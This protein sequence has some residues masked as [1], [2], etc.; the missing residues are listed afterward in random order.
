MILIDGCELMAAGDEFEMLYGD[1]DR[2]LRP[3]LGPYVHTKSGKKIRCK[4][5]KVFA[6]SPREVRY[7]CV[8][9]G[10]P[11]REEFV[12]G[13]ILE[14]AYQISLNHPTLTPSVAIITE[15]A[16]RAGVRS[17]S[18]ESP[19]LYTKDDAEK[20]AAAVQGL[21][22]TERCGYLIPAKV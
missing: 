14:P 2:I 17:I 9:L 11:R 15:A 22:L 7:I 12:L 21:E 16:A 8:S 1:W 5:L 13:Q 3:P 20:L 18:P 6:R 19:T 4:V 10:D